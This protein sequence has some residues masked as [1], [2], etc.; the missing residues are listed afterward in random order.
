MNGPNVVKRIDAPT[1]HPILTLQVGAASK[2]R[3]APTDAAG[4]GGRLRKG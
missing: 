1:N 2:A 3:R 4:V